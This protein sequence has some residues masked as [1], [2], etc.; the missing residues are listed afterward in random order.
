MSDEQKRLEFGHLPVHENEWMAPGEYLPADDGPC[1]IHAVLP[2]RTAL[3][4]KQAGR[5]ATAQVV[6]TKKMDV[7]V[8]YLLASVF[9]VVGTE[10]ITRIVH[11]QLLGHCGQGPHEACDLFVACVV[12]EIVC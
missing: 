11:S 8:R 10:A 4:R 12:V 3:L 7:E 2:R 6:A 5:T 9:P 1:V